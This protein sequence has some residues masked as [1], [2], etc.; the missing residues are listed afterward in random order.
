[1]YDRC[2]RTYTCLSTWVEVRGQLSRVGS[3]LITMESLNKTQ[4]FQKCITSTSIFLEV[5]TAQPNLF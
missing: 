2:V 1:M 5:S 4:V 3:V